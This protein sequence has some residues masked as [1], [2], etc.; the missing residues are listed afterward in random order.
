MQKTSSSMAILLSTAA[1]LLGSSFALAAE[2]DGQEIYT[3]QAG[4]T[5]STI[6]E[7]L[8]T[9]VD[10]LIELNALSDPDA[11]AL[12][13]QLLI[14]AHNPPASPAPAPAAAPAPTPPAPPAGSYTVQPGDT[15]S[16]IATALGTSIEALMQ[17]NNLPDP[18]T[19]MVGQ[20]LV[21]PQPPA[22]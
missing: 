22:P 7:R 3:V 11:L 14:P 8:G 18:D 13:Q 21:V 4:D 20:V 17:A 6:A 1:L 16:G 12:G 9:T 15:L 10:V 2:P 19:L 5:L